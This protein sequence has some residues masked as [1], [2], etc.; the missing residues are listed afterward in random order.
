VPAPKK[1]HGED[2]AIGRWR[3]GLTTKIHVA[4]DALG[5]PVALSL[6]AGQVHD[7]TQA[8]PLLEILAPQAV[9]ADKGIRLFVLLFLFLLLLILLFRESSLNL[10]GSHPHL[11]AVG[12]LNEQGRGN[13]H[14]D[15]SDAEDIAEFSPDYRLIT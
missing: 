12:F 10:G 6:T 14:G 1:K 2:Q 15:R 13:E 9:I 8:D 5:N 3:G 7:V 11:D 4:V